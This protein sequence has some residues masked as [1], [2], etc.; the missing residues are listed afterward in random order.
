[1]KKMPAPQ[2]KREFQFRV[3]GQ[4]REAQIDAVEIGE[5]VGQHQER[6]QPPR[7]GTDR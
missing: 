4:R 6:D 3:H 1:M 2:A 7:D 5:E